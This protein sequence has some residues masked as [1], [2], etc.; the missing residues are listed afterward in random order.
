MVPPLISLTHLD[1][2]Q[3]IMAAQNG[4]MSTLK[5]FV[6]S[7]IDVNSRHPLGWNALHTAVVNGKLDAAKFLVENGADV[8]AKDEFS[9]ALRIAAQ[10]R[11]SS[12]QGT[13][14]F[15]SQ[16]ELPLKCT[17]SIV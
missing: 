17:S 2:R 1:E 4:N 6:K 15:I 8:N 5:K 9:S 12:A 13:N 3:F 14:Q 11:W 10:M 7:G 16:F